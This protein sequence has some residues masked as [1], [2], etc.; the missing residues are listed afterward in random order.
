MTDSV[1]VSIDDIINNTESL[2]APPHAVK[3]RRS[4]RHNMNS[5]KLNAI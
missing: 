5:A 1:T 3:D 2:A 4:F